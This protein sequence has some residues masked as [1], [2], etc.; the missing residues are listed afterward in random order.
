MIELI[1]E[2]KVTDEINDLV[3]LAMAG[4][5]QWEMSQSLLMLFLVI[6]GAHLY[7]LP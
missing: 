7:F 1:Q 5:S 6:S 2:M 4:V 3:S